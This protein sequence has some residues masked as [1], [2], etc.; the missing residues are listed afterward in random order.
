MDTGDDGGIVLIIGSA[1][2]AVLC[3]DWS[4]GAISRIV[5]INNAWRVRA[6]WDYL[7]MPDDF[8]ADRHPRHIRDGQRLIGS[9]TYVP[10]NNRFGGVLYAGGTMAY[11]AGYWALDALRP[12][13]LAFVGCDMIY[14]SRG[15]THFYGT[16]A[17]DPLRKDISLRNLEA[18]A[19]RLMLLAALRG[20]ACVRLSEGDSRLVFPS[21]GRADLS[22]VAAPK[23]KHD[24]LTVRQVREEEQRLGHVEHSGRYWERIGDFPLADLDRL[25]AM[26]LHAA[27]KEI[28]PAGC[29]ETGVRSGPAGVPRS[30]ARSPR[31]CPLPEGS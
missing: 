24:G 18:K 31:H 1:P 4:R 19:S 28:G 16:G 2:D 30:A 10:A 20:C 5:A 6:D 7:V 14:P 22:R 29:A 11:S 13:V 12:S 25:D 9:E 8:P 23:L 26:W 3:R 17:P 27:E 21:V 15:P